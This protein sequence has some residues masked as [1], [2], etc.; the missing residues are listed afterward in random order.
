MRLEP[1]QKLL[2][3]K[4]KCEQPPEELLVKPP[5]VTVKRSDHGSR[6]SRGGRDD[7]RGGSRHGGGGRPRR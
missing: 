7:R 4:L 5:H 6:D 2:G 1:I 3:Q